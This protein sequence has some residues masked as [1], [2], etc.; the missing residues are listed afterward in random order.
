[1]IMYSLEIAINANCADI[2]GFLE[3]ENQFIPL[4]NYPSAISDGLNELDMTVNFYSQRK[5]NT[6]S[7]ATKIYTTKHKKFYPRC[8]EDAPDGEGNEVIRFEAT[9]LTDTRSLVKGL[10]AADNPDIEL[11]FLKRLARL[12]IAFNSEFPEQYQLRLNELEEAEEQWGWIE[13]PKKLFGNKVMCFGK[14][15]KQTKNP[16]EKTPSSATQSTNITINGNV[17]GNVLAGDGNTISQITELPNKGIQQ[18]GIFFSAGNRLRQVREEINLKSSEFVEVLGLSSEKKYQEMEKELDE[19]PLSLLKKVNAVTGVTMEWL[20][21]GNSPRYEVGG[22]YL[23]SIKDG[24]KHCAA[25][26]PQEY[27]LTLELKS[28]HVGLI[29]QTA[30]YRYQVLDTGINLDFWNWA[31]RPHWAVLAFYKF[32]KALSDPWHDICGEIISPEDDKKLYEGNVHYLATSRKRNRS[33]VYDILDI[34]ESRLISP[35]YSKRYGGNWMSR[36]HATFRDYLKAEAEKK[37]T[38]TSGDTNIESN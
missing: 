3:K 34:E 9:R 25:L 4:R 30:E 29:A 6:L 5:D 28:L 31:E 21:H 11:M 36:V 26:N 19:V 24:L 8:Y 13:S 7:I 2:L 17:V 32:L 38:L 18:E 16:E 15:P 14:L 27:F 20:K 23:N 33:L 12:M 22:I 37:Q 10:Y 35:S 1:M